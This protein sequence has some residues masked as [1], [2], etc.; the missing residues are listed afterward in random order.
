MVLLFFCIIKSV[1]GF[2]HVFKGASYFCLLPAYIWSSVHFDQAFS[3]FFFPKIKC[4]VVVS[5]ILLSNFNLIL[6]LM[7]NSVVFSYLEK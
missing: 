2:I 5:I 6:S 3:E 1:N 7:I 4:V